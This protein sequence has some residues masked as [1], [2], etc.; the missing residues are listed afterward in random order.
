M[1]IEMVVENPKSCWSQRGNHDLIDQTARTLPAERNISL[2]QNA[3]HGGGTTDVQRFLRCG[4]LKWVVLPGGLFNSL[5]R[6][7]GKPS[8]WLHKLHD[9]GK[10]VEW[11]WLIYLK[12]SMAVNPELLTLPVWA[13][14]RFPV[15]L[16]GAFSESGGSNRSDGFFRDRSRVFNSRSSSCTKGGVGFNFDSGQIYTDFMILKVLKLAP[17]RVTI[18]TLQKEPFCNLDVIKAKDAWIV[19]GVPCFSEG[20]ESLAGSGTKPWKLDFDSKD[21][22]VGVEL[23]RFS[24]SDCL[25]ACRKSMQK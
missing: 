3:Y 2:M 23:S 5:V 21:I 16:C 22:V 8:E 18:R 11:C 15:R 9:I 12:F 25:T 6:G 10:P 19:E 24:C 1:F 7:L 4:K 14:G 20:A 17:S 13:P